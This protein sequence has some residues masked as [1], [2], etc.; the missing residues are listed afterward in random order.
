MKTP[1]SLSKFLIACSFLAFFS[2]CLSVSLSSKVRKSE[3]VRFVSPGGAFEQIKS[4]GADQAWQDKNIGNSI[5]FQSSCND[6]A[7]PSIEN[8]E[9]DILNNLESAKIGSTQQAFFEGRESRKTQAEGTVDGIATKI[10]ILTFKK[11][12]CLYSISYVSITKNFE[13]DHAIFDKFLEG[14]KAP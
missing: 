2:S 1:R 9:K 5:S 8:I 11:N 13:Q 7:D 14:F 4:P 10:E 3:D 12:S 6:P